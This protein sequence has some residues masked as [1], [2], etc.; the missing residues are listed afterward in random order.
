[1]RALLI[2][3]LWDAIAPFLPPRPPAPKGGHPWCDDR[4]CLQGILFVLREGIRWQS[5]PAELG[6]GSGSTCW[7]RF[8]DWTAAGV[9]PRA[10]HQLLAALGERGQLNCERAV[11]DSASV[12]ALKGGPI[13]AATRPT[14]ASKAASGI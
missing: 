3:E 5:L 1:M 9:W 12:R 4:R 6:W 7:R 11:V 2:D 10:H 14:A 8:R 13:A